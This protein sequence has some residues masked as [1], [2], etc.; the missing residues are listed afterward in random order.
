MKVFAWYFAL[1]NTCHS[2]RWHMHGNGFAQRN[3]YRNCLTESGHK[4]GTA[5]A[6]GNGIYKLMK[7]MLICVDLCQTH[8]RNW[9][10]GLTVS[11]GARVGNRHLGT[12]VMRVGIRVGMCVGVGACA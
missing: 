2:L 10:Q 7:I 4:I 11:V 3:C 5:L 1:V 12:G 6:G 9:E 8:V